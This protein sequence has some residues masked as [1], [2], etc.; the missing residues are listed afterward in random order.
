M[1][2]VESSTRIAYSKMRRDGSGQKPPPTDQRRDRADYRGDLQEAGEVVDDEAAAEGREPAG[3][4]RQFQHADDDTRRHT[5]RPVT[6]AVVPCP[7]R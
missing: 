5:A 6:S 3:R 4:Q 7:P 2:S 1:P